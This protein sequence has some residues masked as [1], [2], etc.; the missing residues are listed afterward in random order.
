MKRAGLQPCDLEHAATVLAA[1]NDAPASCR[2]VASWLQREAARREL[3]AKVLALA[4]KAG[5]SK[6]DA[7]RVIESG[8]AL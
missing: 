3:A 7:R 4:N 6:A 8:A 1:S 5:I 2:L